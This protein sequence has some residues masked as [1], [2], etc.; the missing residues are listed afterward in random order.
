MAKRGYTMNNAEQWQEITNLNNSNCKVTSKLNSLYGHSCHQPPDFDQIVRLPPAMGQGYWRRVRPS[1]GFELVVCDITLQQ[2]LT[3]SSREGGSS[4]NLGFCTGQSLRWSV[5]G[6]REEFGLEIGEVSAYGNLDVSSSCTYEDNKRFQG[7]TIKLGQQHAQGM[8]QHMPLDMLRS[9]LTGSLYVNSRTTPRMQR[10]I[11]D[12]MCCPYEGDIKRIYLEGKALELLAAYLHES[13]LERQASP[14]TQGLSRTDVA[15]LQQA[16][17]I[18]DAELLHPPGIAALA[19]M[20]CLNEYKLKKGFKQLFGMPV[21][22]YVIDQRLEAAVHLLEQGK[23][24][25]TEAAIAAGF[26]KAGHFT[27]HFKRKYG[28][29]PSQFFQQQLRQP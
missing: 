4:L 29:N 20:V 28:M 21:H 9:A 3:M 1:A 5:E 14:A 23:L 17:Q 16:R 19:R 11:H 6:R 8:L 26:G 15:S 25:I 13:L 18:L 27:E 10:I 24:R 22:A 2:T 12:I 7:L